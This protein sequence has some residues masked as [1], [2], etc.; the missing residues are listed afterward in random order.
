M[1]K[2]LSSVAQ[3]AFYPPLTLL[4]ATLRTPSRSCLFGC[5][6]LLQQVAPQRQQV[7]GLHTIQQ[8]LRRWLGGCC[9]SRVRSAHKQNRHSEQHGCQAAALASWMRTSAVMV[10]GSE[11]RGL[12]GAATRTLPLPT[13]TANGGGGGALLP[14]SALLVSPWLCFFLRLKKRS[15]ATDTVQLPC[16]EL[17]EGVARSAASAGSLRPAAQ[18]SCFGKSLSPT[19]QSVQSDDV[20]CMSKSLRRAPSMALAG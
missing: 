6:L 10:V 16:R 15:M 11:A 18:P 9:S 19:W 1:H 2:G 14:F 20:R 17:A 3:P 4:V 13:R 12:P 7:L 5:D 8:G